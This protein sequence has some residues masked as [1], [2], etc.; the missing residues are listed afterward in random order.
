MVTFDMNIMDDLM[1][2][3]F[4]LT[5]QKRQ[6]VNGKNKVS[7]ATSCGNI[8]KEW[9]ESFSESLLPGVFLTLSPTLP[10]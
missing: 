6:K 3:E 1:N 7:Y 9:E 5:I 2:E 10:T 8:R 4:G